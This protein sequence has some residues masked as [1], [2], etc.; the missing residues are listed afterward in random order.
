MI[1]GKIQ[2]QRPRRPLRDHSDE[3]ERLLATLKRCLKESGLTYKDVARTLSVSEATVKR[4]FAGG[5]VTLAQLEHM[6]AVVQIRICDLVELTNAGGNQRARNLSLQQEEGLARSALTSFIFY[7]IRHGWSAGQIREEL[8][9]DEAD[10]TTHL[11]RL[12]KLRVIDLLPA[13]RI[14]LLTAKFPHWLPGGPVRRQFDRTLKIEFSTLDYHAAGV[15]WDLETVKLSRASQGQLRTL[16]DEF[17]RAIRSLADKDRQLP[18][19]EAEWRSVMTISKPAFPELLNRS[20]G[21][22]RRPSY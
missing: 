16:T 17:M 11:I 21:R 18:S 20:R 13:N 8:E 4:H 1:V 10:I 2:G 12:E 7:L 5:T 22:Q 9:L 3:I 14:K 19:N 6:C 15:F